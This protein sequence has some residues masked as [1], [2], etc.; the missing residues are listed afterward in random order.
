M[1][2]AAIPI[3]VKFL[4]LRPVLWIGL[5]HKSRYHDSSSLRDG[6][7][8]DGSSFSTDTAGSEII[9]Q[10]NNYTTLQLWQARKSTLVQEGRDGEIP[11]LHC[12]SR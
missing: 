12:P 1:Y 8:F 2:I 11:G 3:R 5:K 6:D 4:R 10:I 9:A 7:T